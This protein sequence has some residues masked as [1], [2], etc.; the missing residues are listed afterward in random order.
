MQPADG[1]GVWSRSPDAG[2]KFAEDTRQATVAIKPGHRGER[3]ISRKTIAQGRPECF[4]V[5]VFSR[6]LSTFHLAHEAAGAACIRLSLRPLFSRV[7]LTQ[8]SGVPCR[9]NAAVCLVVIAIQSRARSSGLLRGACHWAA[10]RADPLARKD[11]LAPAVSGLFSQA[12]QFPL[13]TKPIM[14]PDRSADETSWIVNQNQ[15]LK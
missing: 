7:E 1:K 3:A 10:L 2:I 5:P 4:G 8:D 15:R 14:V 12:E 6:V 13:V 11:E 9:E